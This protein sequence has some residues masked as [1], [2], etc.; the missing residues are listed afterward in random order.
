MFLDCRIPD[1]V[2]DSGT[3]R[4]RKTFKNTNKTCGSPALPDCHLYNQI[5]ICN[6]VKDEVMMDAL[7]F[8][9]DVRTLTFSF[10]IA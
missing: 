4:Y 9:K 2:N 3:Q 8:C 10:L 6:F 5:I 1:R 7:R